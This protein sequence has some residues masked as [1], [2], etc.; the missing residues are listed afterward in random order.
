MN[1]AVNGQAG[2]GNGAATVAALPAAAVTLQTEAVASVTVRLVYRGRDTMLTLRGASGGEVMTRL[3]AALTWLDQHG[4]TP[5]ATSTSSGQGQQAAAETTPTCPTHGRPMRVGRR[6]GFFCPVKIAEDDG[7]GR[8][9]YC[10]AKVNGG[11]S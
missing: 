5:A 6:G 8:P 4:A 9:V 3:D 1:G 2:A 7:A 10:R 11:G